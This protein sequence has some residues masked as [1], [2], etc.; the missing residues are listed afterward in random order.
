M[1]FGQMWRRVAVLSAV[2]VALA[3][4]VSSEAPKVVA[5]NKKPAAKSTEYFS[6]SLVGVKAS[7]RV[8][9]VAALSGKKFKRLPR[10]GGR[11]MVGKPYKIRGKW[12]SPR[13]DAGYKATG[14]ASWYGD[15]FHGRLTA[16]GEIYDMNHLSA[17]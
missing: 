6:E 5:I 12:Y 8:V 2:S 11:D 15:A 14:T 10:G 7:P 16:N 1:K 4:C 13:E 3:S 9:A 17:A